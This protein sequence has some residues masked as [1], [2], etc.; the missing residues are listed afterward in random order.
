[1]N[2]TPEEFASEARRLT[3]KFGNDEEASHSEHDDLCFRLL[4]SLGY[5]EGVDE[6][7]SVKRWYA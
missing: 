3:T 5:G 6:M 4:R 7:L 1:M 2:M